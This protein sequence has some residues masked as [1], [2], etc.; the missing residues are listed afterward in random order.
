MS[1]ITQ[2]KSFHWENGIIK[3]KFTNNRSVMI[4]DTKIQ[5]KFFKL[6]DSRCKKSQLFICSVTSDNI[7]WDI[8]LFKTPAIKIKKP[9]YFKQIY[10]K[11]SKNLLYILCATITCVVFLKYTK[12]AIV[13]WLCA[14]IYL[15]LC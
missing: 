11:L 4:E 2:I 9:S 13:V 14:I 7:L 8:D 10:N 15:I 1:I 3:L 12:Y 5:E 6:W